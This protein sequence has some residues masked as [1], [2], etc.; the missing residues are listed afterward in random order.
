MLEA[1]DLGKRFGSRWVFRGISFQLQ[2]GDR[3]AVLGSNGT[4]KSTLLRC[5]SGLLTPTEGSIRLPDGDARR[6]LG[7]AALEM[8][9]YPSLTCTEH[10]DLAA[11]LRGCA[12]RAEELLARVGLSHAAA[13]RASQLSTGMKSR[14]RMALSIQPEPLVLLLDEPG[15]ALDEAGKSLLDEIVEEQTNRG[16]LV[17]AT[18]D[19]SERRLATFEL[20]LQLTEAV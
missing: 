14:L 20:P 7:M 18:N 11:D 13:L 10:L 3:L 15:A 19:S 2:K 16:V 8:A 1:H 12:S 5:L 9:L 17:F 6:T 4:G